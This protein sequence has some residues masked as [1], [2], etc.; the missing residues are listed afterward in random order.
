MTYAMDNDVCLSWTKISTA[1]VWFDFVIGV[2]AGFK[3]WAAEFMTV[4]VQAIL[5]K[6]I[7]Y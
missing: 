2:N 7:K 3:F 4:I 5:C 6:L 1:F